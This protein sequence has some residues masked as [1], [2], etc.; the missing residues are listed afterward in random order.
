MKIIDKNMM[1]NLSFPDFEVENT[2]LYVEKKMLKIFVSGAWLNL[3]L[4]LKLG[5][6]ILVFSEWDSILI[7]QFNSK[8]EQWSSIKPIQSE[9]LKDLCE[10]IFSDSTVLLCGFGKK[11]GEWMEWKI[12][13]GTMY[14]EFET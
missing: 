13:G 14:A 7:N 11:T 2:E 3:D 1:Q 6:G 5:K 4:G 12:L 10:F 8:T 9:S